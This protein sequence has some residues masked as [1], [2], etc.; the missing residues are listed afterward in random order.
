MSNLVPVV[1]VESGDVLANS[2][3]VAALF[4]KRHADVLRDTDQVIENISNADLRCQMFRLIEAFDPGANRKIRSF[5]MTKDGFTLLVM[6]YTG[7][8]AMQ[9]KLA[10]IAEF[11]RM[12]AEL[13]KLSAPVQV[14]RLP[15]KTS[16]LTARRFRALINCIEGLRNEI[17]DAQAE[18]SRLRDVPDEI[19]SMQS[20]ISLLELS[21]PDDEDDPFCDE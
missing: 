17:R 3:D 13:R 18:I 10:Y 9:F 6:G 20:R 8:K 14:R 19:R 15:G 11:N 16:E 12:E 1:R 7:P 21:E 4:G 2:R 5:N